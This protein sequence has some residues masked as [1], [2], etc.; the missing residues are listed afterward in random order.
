MAR[1]EAGLRG[2][3]WPVLG[4]AA[5]LFVCAQ[6][7]VL[8][9]HQ[10]MNAHFDAQRFPV[11]AVNLIQQ[12]G[13]R[14]PIFSEDYWGGYLIYR[15]Y[16][17]NRVFV[18]DRHDFYGDDFLKGYLKIIDVEPGWDAALKETN[19]TWILLA[20]NS[21]LT[22]ILKEIPEWKVIYEDKTATLFQRQN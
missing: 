16:P 2:H 12:R 9:S 1:A 22:N 18:D 11:A 5:G 3:L 21:T 10:M 8:G 20:R 14:E 6:H 17:Q 15:L 13:I 4:V 19:P 7:G